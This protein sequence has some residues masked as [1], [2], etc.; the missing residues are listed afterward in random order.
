M[1][2][3]CCLVVEDT[4]LGVQ[5]AK[6]AGMI[7]VAV[8]S[9]QNMK[10]Y[11][12]ADAIARSLLD[13][14]PSAYGLPPFDDWL[15]NPRGDGLDPVLPLEPP[16]RMGGPVV[17]GFGRGSKVLG[18]P[19]ANLDVTPLKFESD[20]LAPGIYFGWAGL[21]GAQGGV[22]GMVMSIGWNPF[23]DNS[24][25]TIEPWLLSEFPEDFYDQELRLTVL[26]YVRP[27]ANFT[28]L[29]ALIARIHRD[30]DV[31]RA[32]LAEERFAAHKEDAYLVEDAVPLKV[33]AAAAAV[34][35]L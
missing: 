26:G 25:K 3:G 2:P 7:A 20:S 10:L 17:K 5:A 30:G 15:P 32:M 34:V 14:D 29:E 13:F 16:V 4:P 27:E 8:P 21:K 9:I 19:T 24:S 28:T 11:Q 31:A 22:Y 33:P 35:A 6:A 12:G 18:I 1:D 23:F